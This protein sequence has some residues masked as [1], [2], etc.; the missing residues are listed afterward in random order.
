MRKTLDTTAQSHFSLAAPP[1]LDKQNYKEHWRN[2]DNS[3][4]YTLELGGGAS[5]PAGSTKTYQDTG[6]NVRLGAGYQFNRRIAVLAQYDFNHFGVPK[7]ISDEL[8][9]R[10]GSSPLS[11][12]DLGA[13][14]AVHLWSLT[15]NPRVRYVH[16]EKVDAYVVAGGGFYRKLVRFNIPG[17]C[18][19]LASCYF[20]DWPKIPL[21]HSSNNAGGFSAGTGIEWRV[22]YLPHGRY[23]VEG[24]YVWVD[25]SST[26]TVYAPASY[27]TGYFPI[28]AGLRW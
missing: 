24:R 15:L 20:I 5:L 12:A 19:T 21:S 1:A 27:R 7:S 25:N 3:N 17:E 2:S 10:P 14:G 22:S 6:F 28:T 23:F 9:F 16:T 18:Q 4:K 26:N 11:G 13:S 8:F